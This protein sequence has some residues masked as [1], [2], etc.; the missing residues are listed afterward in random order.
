MTDTT[1][2]AGT[3]AGGGAAPATTDTNADTL[4]RDLEAMRLSEEPGD[5]AAARSEMAGRQDGAG[6]DDAAAAAAAAEGKQQ[7]PL[8][9][10]EINK[11]WQDQ[12]AATKQERIARQAGEAQLEEMRR[13]IAALKAGRTGGQ[14]QQQPAAEDDDPLT[15]EI[16]DPNEDP[17]GAFLAMIKLA[18]ALQN[19][20]RSTD[21]Q[22]QEAQS[23]RT[24]VQQLVSTF[25]SAENEYRQVQPDY[26]DAIGHMR[27]QRI[28]E[29]QLF[30]YDKQQATQAYQR[31][32]FQLVNA[33]MQSNQHP[34]HVIYQMAKRRG[35][36]GPKPAATDPKVAAVDM[37]RQVDATKLTKTLSGSGGKTVRG[38]PTIEQAN[39]TKDGDAF[40]KMFEEL[41]AL[42]NGG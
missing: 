29:L 41:R 16:P 5:G 13:E 7:E 26:D 17:A 6:Q 1:A 18:R 12:K 20:R 35:Y 34:A 36:A 3:D 37:Q 24:Q 15:S 23:S 19:D 39:D 38:G 33:S 32:I 21:Q 10:E 31:E 28:E 2:S 9:P 8:T 11:R 25:Q 4:D 40:D 42:N 30:G 27:D 22:T 14:Q